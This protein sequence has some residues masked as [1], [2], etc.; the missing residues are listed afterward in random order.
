MCVPRLVHEW[1][2]SLQLKGVVLRSV[3]RRAVFQGIGGDVSSGWSQTSSTLVLDVELL[4]KKG[5]CLVH[6]D[7][8]LPRLL[9][10]ACTARSSMRLSIAG[11]SGRCLCSTLYPRRLRRTVLAGICW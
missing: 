9:S 1:L 3:L 11:R 4:C 7:R 6:T 5:A 2:R 10:V 8:Q